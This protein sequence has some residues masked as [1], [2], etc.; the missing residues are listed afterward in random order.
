MPPS[1]LAIET[2]GAVCSAAALSG[3]AVCTRSVRGGRRHDAE[4]MGM[5]DAV[6]AE[7]ELARGDVHAIA[8][9]A[10]PGS[11]TG[12]RIGVS[13]AKALAEALG[14]PLVAVPSLVACALASE[15]EGNLLV[16][17][18]SRRKE[19]FAA[20]VLVS[21]RTARQVGDT[22]AGE[23]AAI[24]SSLADG[25]TAVVGPGAD[26]IDRERARVSECDAGAVARVGAAMLSIGEVVD[27]ELFEPYYLKEFVAGTP[28]TSVFARLPF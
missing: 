3:D 23:P 17:F 10:G 21:E 2:S 6:L 1:V 16:A 7:S 12:L 24:L 26:R 15:L 27:P 25:L 28:T 5:I 8:V 13:V 9:S 11:Y 4:L 22:L 14:R 19:V 20:R 18:P